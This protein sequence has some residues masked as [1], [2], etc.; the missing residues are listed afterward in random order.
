MRLSRQLEVQA[1]ELRA[2]KCEILREQQARNAVEAEAAKARRKLK[3]V[4]NG[5]CPCCN[6]SFWNLE[7][8]MK[9]KHP[10]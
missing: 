3:R 7:R 4:Q 1:A 8:H 2:A 6:R 10:K 9:S 5:V